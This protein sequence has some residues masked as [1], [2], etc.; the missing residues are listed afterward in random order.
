M[1]S[2]V[3]IGEEISSVI[4]P[5][6][7]TKLKLDMHPVNK[8]IPI[9]IAV[10]FLSI[11]CFCQTTIKTLDKSFACDS[12]LVFL[13]VEDMPDY[14]GGEEKLKLVLQEKLKFEKSVKGTAYVQ[15]IV[16]CNG[17]AVGHFLL[18]GFNDEVDSKV[19]E[20]V[21]KIQNWKVGK[22]RGKAVDC[23]YT[24]VCKFKKGRM[25]L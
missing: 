4:C 24:V 10:L 14:F 18:L 16:D 20:E 13:V 11:D 21:S 9:I 8:H 12:N 22:H 6:V 17:K 19:L 3:E 7:V 15:F 23:I 2:L 5:L 25:V 1:C